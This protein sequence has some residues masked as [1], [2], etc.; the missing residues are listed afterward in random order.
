MLGP[1][2]LSASN[3]WIAHWILDH[4]RA[5]P[6]LS[7]GSLDRSLDFGSCSGQ[8][9]SQPRITGI[10][11][12]FW[13]MLGPGPLS[14]SDHWIA[15]WILDHARAGPTHSLQSPDTS[16]DPSPD[17]RVCS[18]RVYHECLNEAKDFK[19]KEDK[20]E[21]AKAE[22]KEKRERKAEQKLTSSAAQTQCCHSA[23]NAVFDMCFILIKELNK[24]STWSQ[25]TTH[26]VD[27]F[28]F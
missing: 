19:G 27:P 21:K 20:K 1:G 2:P 17:P 14:A 8:A 10:L 24:W 18:S 26:P 7:L 16:S 12:G 22:R 25:S 15:H 5:R 4:A 3:H 28:Y 11:T 6:T 13:I 23:I 9:R